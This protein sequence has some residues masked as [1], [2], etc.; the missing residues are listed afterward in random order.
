[1]A[2]KQMADLWKD[3]YFFRA[4]NMRVQAHVIKLLQLA[5]TVN[6]MTAEDKETVEKIGELSHLLKEGLGSLRAEKFVEL[7]QR[8]AGDF[9]RKAGTLVKAAQMQIARA[10]AK[11]E[12]AAKEAAEKAAKEE[13]EAKAA[14]ERKAK[15]EEETALAQSTFDGLVGLRL[16]TLDWDRAQKE[17]QRVMGEMTTLEGKDAMRTQQKKVDCMK[18]LHQLFI[19][20]AKGFQFKSGR[21]VTATVADADAKSIT[22]QGLR[23]VRGKSVADGDPKKLDW[24]RFFGK[25]EY[26]GYMNQLI[27]QLVMNGRETIKTSARAWSEQMF[28]AALALQLLYSEVEGAAEFAPTLVKKAAADFEPSR[29]W[30]KKMFPEIDVGEVVE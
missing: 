13:A 4:S 11:A 23:T 9:H 2:V 26:V 6:G 17:L 8:R 25:K 20:K 21:A 18:A 30:A 5:E 28:G 22:I 19:S 7:T 1:M 24:T 29:K 27:N 12:Q 3:V 10:K 16:K 14:E 15:I